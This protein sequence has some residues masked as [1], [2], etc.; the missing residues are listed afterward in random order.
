MALS[1]R[2][3]EDKI[4]RRSSS[5]L[6]EPLVVVFYKGEIKDIVAGKEYGVTLPMQRK[7]NNLKVS[8]IYRTLP[9]AVYVTANDG[10]HVCIWVSQS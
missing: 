4:Y 6:S 2:I 8:K 3:D 10:T 9:D 1:I 7:I 5:W